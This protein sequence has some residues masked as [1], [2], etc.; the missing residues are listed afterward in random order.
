MASIHAGRG[1]GRALVVASFLAASVS[2]HSVWLERAPEGVVARFG[3]IEEGERD[4]LKSKQ[5]WDL[6]R[7]TC[8]SGGA[9]PVARLESDRVVLE[10]ACN[11]PLLVHADMPVH[12][13]G[14]EAGRA[15]FSARFAPDS[16]VSLT[17]DPALGL[18][19][20][21]VSR[22]AGAV[23]VL[24]EGKPLAGHKVSAIGPSKASLEL[25]ADSEGI[26]RLAPEST[27]SW[28]LSSYV[29]EKRSGTHKGSKFVKIWHVATIT[30]ERR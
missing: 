21:P 20:V 15:I 6:A 10:G 7:A 16:G 9:A 26:V 11:A 19:L 18:D 22:A 2:A 8:P 13:K 14:K 12:G 29:E 28:T 27:G 30:L 23:R 24:R 1:I 25:V 17:M 3:E 5:A 4:T